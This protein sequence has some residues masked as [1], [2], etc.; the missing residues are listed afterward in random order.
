MCPNPCMCSI[1]RMRQGWTLLVLLRLFFNILGLK[2]EFDQYLLGYWLFFLVILILF[3]PHLP[4]LVV[5][6]AWHQSA[7]RSRGSYGRI[8]EDLD[9]DDVVRVELLNNYSTYSFGVKKKLVLST[10]SWLGGK[11]DFL[12]MAYVYVG[13]SSIFIALA[14]ML[15]H[16]KNPR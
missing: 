7:K 13:S 6:D 16:V 12:G 4:F 9:V 11:N 3:L 14:F 1:N 15:L 10:A 5:W 8:E 2:L